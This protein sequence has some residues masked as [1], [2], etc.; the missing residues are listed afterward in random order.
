MKNG[1]S[2]GRFR[3]RLQIRYGVR[4]C[5]LLLQALVP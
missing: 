3:F 5:E 4:N 2:R 1:P